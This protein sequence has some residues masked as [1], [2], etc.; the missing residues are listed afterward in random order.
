[1]AASALRSKRSA[2]GSAADGPADSSPEADI[3]EQL[4]EL[5]RLFEGLVAAVLPGV[6]HRAEHLVEAG[7]PAARLR[8]PV[9]PAE[10]RLHAG[11]RKTDSGQPPPPVIICT[12]SM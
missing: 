11:V 5:L 10:K 12:A 7:H 4:R 6:G 3:A 1:M 2:P 8:R 9:R